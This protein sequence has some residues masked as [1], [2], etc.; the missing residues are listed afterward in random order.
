MIGDHNKIYGVDPRLLDELEKRLT[1][2]EDK[3]EVIMNFLKENSYQVTNAIG[4]EMK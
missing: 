3:L 2:I 1:R 4:R